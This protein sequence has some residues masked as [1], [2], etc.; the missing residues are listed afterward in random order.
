MYSLP[1]QVENG[2]IFIP[3]Y[4]YNKL[5]SSGMRY[6]IDFERK[7]LVFNSQE[8]LDKAI[9]ILSEGSIEQE[10]HLEPETSKKRGKLF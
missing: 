2:N 8:D 10:I 5:K 9:N 1:M 4:L 3:T 7:C 6:F